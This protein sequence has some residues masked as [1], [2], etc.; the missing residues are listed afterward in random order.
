MYNSDKSANYICEVKEM[1]KF[2]TLILTAG[3]ILTIII[4]NSVGF[5]KDGRKLDQL[6]ESVLRLHILADSDSEEDQ[7]LKLCVRDA[8]LERSG[9]LFGEADDL[10]SAEEAALEAL[11][12]IVDIAENTLRAQGCDSPVRAY[13]ADMEFDERVYGNITMPAGKY[14]AL[15][16]EIGEAKGHNWW[17][18]M[19]P[20]LC[21]PAAE[22][23]ESRNEK[24]Y[25]DEKELDIVYRPKK[26][27][28]K[29]AIWDKFKKLFD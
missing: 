23:V 11:P 15:R 12:E 25:Y 20:P 14:R 2:H 4:S 10:E 28:I 5:I 26:Y 29:F 17:C 24:E 3:F 19:Y 16:I 22:K 8:L 13:L 27:R 1:K 9:E 18:V 7:R 6:R 21:I